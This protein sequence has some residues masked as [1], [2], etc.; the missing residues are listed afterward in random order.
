RF[1]Y[2]CISAL[3]RSASPSPL[4]FIGLPTK[5][6]L[7]SPESCGNRGGSTLALQSATSGNEK[8]RLCSRPSH[9]E[10]NVAQVTRPPSSLRARR[11]GRRHQRGSHT[12][13]NSSGTS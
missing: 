9:S 10:K 12:W 8:G 1:Q 13:Q 6:T 2:V 3:N 7:T 4:L 5:R 11:R